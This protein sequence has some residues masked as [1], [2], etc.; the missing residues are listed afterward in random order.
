MESAEVKVVR[1]GNSYVYVHDEFAHTVTLTHSVKAAVSIKRYSSAAD[2][3]AYLDKVAEEF[4]GEV[5]TMREVC[6][7][8]TD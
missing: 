1:I 5:V 2:Y 7:G 3:D 6:D 8:K 4:G